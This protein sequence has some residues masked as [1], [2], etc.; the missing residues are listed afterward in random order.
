MSDSSTLSILDQIA[1]APADHYRVLK[2]SD[3]D[4]DRLLEL[5]KFMKLSLSRED[6]LAIQEIYRGWER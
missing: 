4:G 1:E 3:L 5:S 6:M 2:I